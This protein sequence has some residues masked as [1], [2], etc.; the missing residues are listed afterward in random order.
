[1]GTSPQIPKKVFVIEDEQYLRDLYVQLLTQ[2]GYEVSQAADGEEALKKIY[3]EEYDLILLDIILPKVDGLHILENVSLTKK[4]LLKR[5][6]LLTN[7]SQE[8]VMAQALQYGVRGYMV[9][10]DLTPLQVLNE[11]KNY[12]TQIE[13]SARTQP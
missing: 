6:V 8:I 9:K 3:A 7:L 2:E 4:T 10:S 13:A 1:M 5:V 12:I 11:V